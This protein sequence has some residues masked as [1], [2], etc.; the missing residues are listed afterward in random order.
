MEIRRAG[1][2]ELEAVVRLYADAIEAMRGT[3]EDIEWDLRWHPTRGSLAAAV[4]A[5]ELYAAVEEGRVVGAFVLNGV[6]V[7]AYAQVPWRLAAAPGDVSVLHLLAV[8]PAARGRG[9]GARLVREALRLAEEAGSRTLRLDVLANNKAA[10][11]LYRSC[12]LTDLGVFE[13]EVDE[14][15]TRPAHAMDA[16]FAE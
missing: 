7:P 2:P 11:S 3:P 10:A 12:G 5:G 8:S 16:V 1:A 4:A 9:V 13:L 14:G 15:F 6:Q